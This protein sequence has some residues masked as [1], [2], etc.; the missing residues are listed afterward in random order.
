MN[1]TEWLA[2]DNNELIFKNTLDI[3]SKQVKNT[4]KGGSPLKVKFTS[5]NVTTSATTS[6]TT[7][8]TL[9]W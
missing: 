9:P 3:V 5:G 7:G 4:A 2:E 8:S 1:G 6:T